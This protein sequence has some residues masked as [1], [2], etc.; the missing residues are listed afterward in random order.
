MT[1]KPIDLGNQRAPRVRIWRGQPLHPL[2]EVRMFFHDQGPVPETFRRL[3]ERLSAAGI[4]HIFMGATAVN[5]HGYRRSTEDI[6]V[7]MTRASL[8]R[9]RSEFV[10]RVYQQ[11]EGRTRR[12]HDPDTQVTIDI[13]VAGEIAGDS[14]RQ[15]RIRFPDSSEAELVQGTPVPT[16][17]RLIELKLVT[18]R[19]KDWAD[20]VELIRGHDLNESFADRVDP[21]VR[22]A[23][24]QCLD[25]K[26]EE[27]RYNPE[28]HDA[29]P[30][31]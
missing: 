25:Q 23:Y 12:F 17:V 3:R 1:L 31:G 18:W 22:M 5:V 29:P 27:D 28:I 24:L 7:C 8:E 14:R 19:Y 26:R 20:V 10:G 4:P 30:E 2:E 11:V 6:D 15:Q 13:L 9:F 16:L 21:I